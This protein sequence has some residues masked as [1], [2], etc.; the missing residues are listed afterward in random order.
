MQSASNKRNLFTK[1]Q[2]T[3]S[4][5]D[6]TIKESLA[7]HQFYGSVGENRA[8]YKRKRQALTILFSTHSLKKRCTSPPRLTSLIDPDMQV[9]GTP[10]GVPNSSLAPPSVL[11]CRVTRRPACGVDKY[12]CFIIRERAQ[13]SG[14][15]A[16]SPTP[17]TRHAITS[18][19]NDRHLTSL[20]PLPSSY[21]P[22]PASHGR[23]SPSSPFPAG[24]IIIIN[25]NLTQCSLLLHRFVGKEYSDL[26]TVFNFFSSFARPMNLPGNQR[27][28]INCVAPPFAEATRAGDKQRLSL[29]ISER[30]EKRETHTHILAPLHS[31]CTTR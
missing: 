23:P 9:N 29:C 28:L 7:G 1:Q 4:R 24:I 20:N 14:S 17:A 27:L 5:G 31:R 30:E 11:D 6:N 13:F 8:L 10:R 12:S 16:I 25:N 3:R 2:E 26:F 21:L 22:P 18:L 19:P 15:R